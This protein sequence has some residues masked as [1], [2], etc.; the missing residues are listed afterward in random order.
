[1]VLVGLLA[2]AVSLHACKTTLPEEP[3]PPETNRPIEGGI[4]FSLREGY[5]PQ[6]EVA[7]PK[8]MLEMETEKIYGCYNF[9]IVA[10]TCFDGATFEAD[11][12]GIYTPYICLTALGPATFRRP[13]DLPEGTFAFLISSADTVDRY[14]VTV[15]HS[16]IAIE[17]VET[18]FTEPRWNLAWRYPERSFTSV[19]SAGDET[20]W[21]CGAF[22]DSLLAMPNIRSF[23]FPDSG[24]VPYPAGT[25]GH[26]PDDIARYY[27][28]ES[29]SDY[30]AAGALLE[31][32]ALETLPQYPDVRIYLLNYRNEK[33]RS[34]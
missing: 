34:W 18:H 11:L 27:R 3:E 6:G 1:M 31:R 12:R 10:R 15:L 20:A 23:V 29:E 16:S 5:E 17:A 7:D 14:E 32:F 13:I 19:C 26:G 8:I 4:M 9:S 33:F 22:R 25:P 2:L 24:L 30:V 28:Y 21:V